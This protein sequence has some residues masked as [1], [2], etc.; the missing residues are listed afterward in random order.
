[1]VSDS[2]LIVN[3]PRNHIVNAS[4]FS[5]NNPSIKSNAG[6]SQGI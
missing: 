5:I 1:M 4:E 2:L 6:H 3:L